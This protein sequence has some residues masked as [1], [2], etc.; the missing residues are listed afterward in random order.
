MTPVL[1]PGRMNTKINTCPLPHIYLYRRSMAA[2]ISGVGPPLTSLP[3]GT[4]TCSSLLPSSVRLTQP[5][6]SQRTH[7]DPQELCQLLFSLINRSPVTVTPHLAAHVACLW[8]KVQQRLTGTG[9][10][11]GF[12][13]PSS[14]QPTS[15]DPVTSQTATKVVW[16]QRRL[17]C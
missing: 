1:S 16:N 15:G 2:C 17:D 14:S 10:P 3:P 9:Q 7:N 4:G 12:V 5:G 8:R 6:T 11:T 13:W